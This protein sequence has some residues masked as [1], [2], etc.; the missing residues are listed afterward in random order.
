MSKKPGAHLQQR[1]ALGGEALHHLEHHVG[2]AADRQL[3]VAARALLGDRLGNHVH[4][5]QQHVA[6]HEGVVR[7]DIALLRRRVLQVVAGL[8][9]ELAHVDVGRQAGAAQGLH[10]VQVGIVAEHPVDQ[11]RQEVALQ[12]ALADRLFQAE[13]GDDGQPAT[14]VGGDAAVQRV[15]EGVG[16]ADGQRDAQHDVTGHGGQHRVH[17]I[18]KVVDHTGAGHGRSPG[19]RRGLAPVSRCRG[20]RSLTLRKRH[21]A[22]QK[23]AVVPPGQGCGTPRA[24]G[25]CV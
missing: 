3:P 6:R 21:R 16:L 18:G 2:V 10:V 4:A 12:V 8:Q 9:E 13:R 25:L 20:G 5:L 17:R 11:R 15:D 1:R 14:G 19:C 7:G 23:C 22:G 24:S